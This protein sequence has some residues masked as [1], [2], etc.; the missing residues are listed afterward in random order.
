MKIYFYS[1]IRTRNALYTNNCSI[2]LKLDDWQLTYLF[3]IMF[4]PALMKGGKTCLL[5]ATL[6]QFPSLNDLQGL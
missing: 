3:G 5:T 1:G 2:A 4:Y 6:L